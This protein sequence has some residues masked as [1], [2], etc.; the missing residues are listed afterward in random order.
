MGTQNTPKKYTLKLRYLH[1]DSDL[2]NCLWDHCEGVVAFS[3]HIQ[4]AYVDSCTFFGLSQ[5]LQPGRDS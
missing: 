4:K 2:K 1:Y 5:L 3:I